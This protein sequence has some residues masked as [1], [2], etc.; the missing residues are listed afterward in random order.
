VNNLSRELNIINSKT[1]AQLWI[2]RSFLILLIFVILSLPSPIFPQLIWLI[3]IGGIFLMLH[4]FYPLWK[5]GTVINEL[6]QQMPSSLLSAASSIQA[7][8][9]PEEAIQHLSKKN[10]PPLNL[11]FQNT[12]SLSTRER[13]ELG[14]S[15]QKTLAI[16]QTPELDRTSSI[17]AA[18]IKSGANLHSLFNKVARDLL[19]IRGLRKEQIQQMKSLKYMLFLAGVILIPSILALSVQISS[20]L[21]YSSQNLILSS[22]ISFIPFSI[23]LSSIISYFCE[24]KPKKISIYIPVFLL[25]QFLVFNSIFIFYPKV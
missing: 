23:I 20:L 8:Q 18:G 7:G 1:P 6:L 12:I 14:E 5:C 16:Y 22:Q 2:A 10:N 13:I 25:L 19:A 15:L 3:P 9:T 21:G 17:L 11:I 4:L 24:F